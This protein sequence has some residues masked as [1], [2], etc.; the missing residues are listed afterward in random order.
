MRETKSK[1]GGGD[2]SETA[3][4]PDAK[5]D[6]QHSVAALE[7]RM[8][9]SRA[10]GDVVIPGLREALSADEISVG[11]LESQKRG[12][13]VW[14]AKMAAALAALDEARE[15]VV[16]RTVAGV[17]DLKSATEIFHKLDGLKGDCALHAEVIDAL[18]AE[19]EQKL[20]DRRKVED[21]AHRQKLY[22]T[23]L[24]SRRAAEETFD[25]HGPALKASAHAIVRALAEAEIT[26]REAN[27]N[28]PPGVAE[29]HSAEAF[30]WTPPTCHVAEEIV[31]RWVDERGYEYGR[32]GE[33]EGL[34]QRPDGSAIL[35]DPNGPG[36]TIRGRPIKV[37]KI[38]FVEV[39]TTTTPGSGLLIPFA[40]ALAIPALRPGE[41]EIW[42][43][44]EGLG[45]PQQVLAA[46]AKAISPPRPITA[47]TPNVDVRRVPRDIYEARK[48]RKVGP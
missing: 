28:L 24:A 41:P 8:A 26:T 11:A 43:P 18:D 36:S 48:G 5:E 39:T 10:H 25:Q 32:V 14:R 40:S 44:V 47:Q 23:A 3:V 16:R 29:L 21:L 12:I 2:E 9:A 35:P 27:K 33:V 15:H 45:Q 30:R 22:E 20:A 19:L 46:L 31:A 7:S 34:D 1:A 37:R 17:H 13:S 4:P 42:K 38:E 6:V